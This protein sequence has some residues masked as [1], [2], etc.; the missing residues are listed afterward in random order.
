MINVTNSDVELY[1]SAKC[2]DVLD[3]SYV[4]ARTDDGQGGSAIKKATGAAGEDIVGVAHVSP[5]AST[6]RAVIGEVHTVDADNALQLKNPGAV[7]DSISVFNKTTGLPMPKADYA[8]TSADNKVTW[9]A[10]P[11]AATDV[12]EVSYLRSVTL[13]ELGR[14][15][16]PLDHAGRF[17]AI[18]DH[19][20]FATGDS[21]IHTDFFDTSEAFVVGAPVFISAAGVPTAKSG[22]KQLGTVERA[23]TAAYPILGVAGKWK[24]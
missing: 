11:P 21:V 12:L 17:Q 18:G 14:E 5:F 22:T 3:N 4:V 7:G 6:N 23:P 15:G 20:E 16:L 19:A 1:R 13:A 2:Q 24:F 10:T 9:S 8:F